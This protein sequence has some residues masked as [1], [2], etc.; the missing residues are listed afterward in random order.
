M[1]YL[2]SG[3]VCLLGL[4]SINT[5]AQTEMQTLFGKSKNKIQSLGFYI[6]PELS[7]GQLNSSFSPIAGN[8]VMLTVNKKFAIGVTA[9]GTIGDNSATT[10][11]GHFGGLKMEYT[12]KP[13]ALVHVSFPLIIGAGS[14][15]TRNSF[16]GFDRRGRYDDRF[17]LD[18]NGS[19]VLQPGVNVEANLFK[20]AK[21][22]LGANY[23]LAANKSGYNADLSGFSSSLGLKFGVFD[24]KLKKKIKETVEPVE[25]V[26]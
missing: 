26:K 13:A 9:S 19:F 6:A 22:F 8:S 15:A 16:E 18:R 14:T 12:P 4:I 3:L 2:K 1:N 5:M 17:D 23:R 11:R 25:E 20:Y 21:V 24:H 7:F 10:T